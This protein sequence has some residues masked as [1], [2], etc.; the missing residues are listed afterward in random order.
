MHYNSLL[1]EVHL[2][3]FGTH[4]AIGGG[5]QPLQ[6][7]SFGLPVYSSLLGAVHLVLLLVPAVHLV[8]EIGMTVKLRCIVL[9]LILIF[10]VIWSIPIVMLFEG[11][12]VFFKGLNL[13][14]ILPFHFS[15]IRLLLEFVI[16]VV[17]LH[18]GL[19]LVDDIQM[20]LSFP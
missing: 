6:V 14:E 13:L 7:H 17:F 1:S 12:M 5:S 10:P 15:L 20:I 11:L 16:E 3:G 9:I 18:R 4:F 19:F 8:V 2:P